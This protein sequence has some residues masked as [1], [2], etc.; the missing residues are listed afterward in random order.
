MPSSTVPVHVPAA[1]LPAC[2]LGKLCR[3]WPKTLGPYAQVRDQEKISWL[4]IG[5]ALTPA[6]IREINQWMEIFLSLLLSVDLFPMKINR[7][8]KKITYN[9]MIAL[10]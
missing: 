1:V 3:V 4:W 2:G 10:S 8:E 5:T 9:L 6:A 7:S